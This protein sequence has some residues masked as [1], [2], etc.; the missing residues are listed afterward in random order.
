M[1][2][3]Q[4]SDY[5]LRLVLYLACHPGRAVS[6]DEVSRAYGD[7]KAPPGQGG[8][9][10]H[11]AGGGR[12]AARGRGGGCGS[13][14]GPGGDQH[15]RVD[16]PDRLHFHMCRNALIRDEYAPDHPLRAA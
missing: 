14:L 4:F 13:R 6:V 2:L 1:H 8:A 10:D 3:T 16:P 5:S 12:G 7:F 9:N 15:R 11:G